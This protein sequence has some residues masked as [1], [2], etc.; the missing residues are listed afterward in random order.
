MRGNDD[1]VV[2]RGKT[3]PTLYGV[4][5]GATG[6]GSGGSVVVGVG[7]GVR[8]TKEKLNQDTKAEERG[9]QQDR[10]AGVP[11][12]RDDR[13]TS[14]A[15]RRSRRNSVTDDSHLTIEN[16]GGSQDNLA[17]LGR[18]PDKD[19]VVVHGRRPSLDSPTGIDVPKVAGTPSTP[20]TPAGINSWRRNKE[21]SRSQE[22][23]SDFYAL[24]NRTVDA[25][26][27]LFHQQQ[28]Q[29]QRRSRA[30][31]PSRMSA[32][33]SSSNGAAKHYVVY[34]NGPAGS[35]DVLYDDAA[36]DAG[37]SLAA[38]SRRATNFAELS[39]LRDNL[40]NSAINIVYMQQQDKESAGS[41][42][43][44]HRKMNSSGERKPMTI[45]EATSW[46]PQSPQISDKDPSI[47]QQQQQQ[48]QQHYGMEAIEEMDAAD[49]YDIRM[50]M[51]EKRKRI[52]AEKRHMELMATKQREKVGK[53][54]FL[55]V[56]PSIHP[57]IHPSFSFQHP[58]VAKLTALSYSMVVSFEFEIITILIPSIPDSG[59]GLEF[60]Y[61]I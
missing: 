39:K 29:Q 13:K 5:D 7:V 21:W 54:A 38:G 8:P 18:N 31:S 30:N 27:E 17:L 10:S 45:A 60:A 59:I 22:N 33:S 51:E 61:T 43:Q 53:A 58:L 2:H 50:K 56:N 15:G 24:D 44:Q 23:V 4:A 47:Q 9:E 49:L 25:E 3:V 48:Q 52:E 26:E 28:Q 1:F 20:S 6:H 41:P 34:S 40:G 16:F 32:G 57:S 37:S 14:F 19:P 55:Q 42:L 12:F 35:E 36:G 11:S 46:E